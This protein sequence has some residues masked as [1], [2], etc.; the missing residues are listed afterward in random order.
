MCVDMEGELEKKGQNPGLVGDSWKKR[1]FVYNKKTRELRYYMTLKGTVR[2]RAKG[3]I[4]P[5][6]DLQGATNHRENRFDFLVENTGGA[7]GRNAIS[8]CA[9]D[10]DTRQRWLD[11]IG[12]ED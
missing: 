8:V 7:Q 1:H 12:T 6:Q 4:D 3:A 9:A 11:A 10:E 2:L 5:R